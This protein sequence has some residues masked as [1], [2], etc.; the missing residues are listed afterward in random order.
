M[1]IAVTSRKKV[2]GPHRPFASLKLK[3]S[4]I[5]RS[6]VRITDMFS[7]DGNKRMTAM[8]QRTVDL[9]IKSKKPSRKAVLESLKEWQVISKVTKK[10][11]I[12]M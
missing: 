5:E 10:H 2:N 1:K 4:Y 6:G 8:L 12:L 3:I 7:E 9:I 11:S